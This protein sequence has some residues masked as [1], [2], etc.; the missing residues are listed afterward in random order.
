M[1]L[2]SRQHANI[3]AHMNQQDDRLKEQKKRLDQYEA[4]VKRLELNSG[5]ASGAP[6]ANSSGRSRSR[7]SPP[8]RA[9]VPATEQSELRRLQSNRGFSWLSPRAGRAA[10][11]DGYVANRTQPSGLRS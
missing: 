6:L 3:L 10:S 4:R 8:R 7:H 1:A 9:R 11:R 2:L 5:S